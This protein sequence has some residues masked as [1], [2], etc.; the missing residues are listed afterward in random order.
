MKTTLKIFLFSALLLA[1][2]FVFPFLASAKSAFEIECENAQ[3]ADA[4]YF[5]SYEA[6]SVLYSKNT[7]KIIYPA[8]TVKI[9]TGLVACEKLEKRLSESVTITEEMLKGHTGTSMG[10]K[11]GMTL[12]V[13]DLLYGAICGGCNDAAQALA[14]ICSGS[15]NAFV[16][17]MNRY[18]TDLEMLATIYKNPTGLDANGAQTTISDIAI[19][20]KI[21]AKNSLYMEISSAKNYF[22]NGIDGKEAV[23]YNRNALISH[24]TATEYLNEFA[25]GL[26]AG[27]T[28]KGGYVVSTVAKSDDA[29]YLCIVMGAQ[30]EGRDIYSYKIANELICNAFSKY[31]LVKISSKNEKISSLPVN[32]ALSTDKEISVSCVTEGD[33]Y[34]F[35]PKNTDLKKGLEYRAYFHD[36]DLI[37][38]INKGDVLGGLNIYLDGVLVGST[39]IVS[40]DTVE[41]NSFL[42]FMKEMK[43]F[44]LSGYFLIFILLLIPSLSI[45]LYFD[46]VKFRRRKNVGYI[47]F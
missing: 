41:E 12:S 5:Y 35:I 21:A 30:N 42:I 39:R 7:D 33:V 31:A 15:V 8:S 25:S 11:S 14:V 3:Y 27:S 26:N 36:T 47:R 37:A 44:L 23:I 29:T 32:C 13:K 38:P 40:N 6:K 10:L 18:A 2:L 20:S 34:A 24:F 1:A 28:D 16:D 45:F 19:L 4:I 46:Y 43:G 17:E 9:M 22:Y